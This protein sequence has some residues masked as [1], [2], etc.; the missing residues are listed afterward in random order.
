MSIWFAEDT[1][2]ISPR[3]VFG[4]TFSKSETPRWYS[5]QLHGVA[6]QKLGNL[7]TLKLVVGE[8]Y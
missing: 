6:N 7:A 1:I 5:G 3:I 4:A 2:I 8:M